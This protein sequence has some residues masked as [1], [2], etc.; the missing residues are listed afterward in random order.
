MLYFETKINIYIIIIICF[1]ILL[2][3][4]KS[5]IIIFLEKITIKKNMKKY[6]Q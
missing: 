5:C 2:V 6:F 3:F 4:I 1:I